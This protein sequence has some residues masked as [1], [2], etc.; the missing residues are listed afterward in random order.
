V[1]LG[2]IDITVKVSMSAAYTAAPRNGHLQALLHLFAYL[3][4]HDR[5]KLVFDD[6]YVKITD[7]IDVDWKEFYR[8]ARKDIPTNVPEARG[9]EVKMTV[10][11][12]A[13]YA[14]DKVTRRSRIGV[15]LYLN[16]SP[17]LWYSKKQNSVETSTFG[18]EFSALR[19]AMELTKSMRLK[20]RMMGIPL[21]GQAHFRV[22][23]ML[24]VHNMTNP[25]SMLK[26][27]SNEISYHYVREGMAS[28]VGR[29]GYEE[30]K[31]NHADM[32]TQVQTGIERQRIA[33][34][35]LY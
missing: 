1:E 3:N 10:F 16:K 32:L 14:G 15:L 22:N 19:T 4:K 9:R 29:V 21:D 20:L 8:N 25:G 17:I 24:V 33:S 35:V 7:E 2:R 11:V 26:K 12:D 6:S 34:C 5:S 18:S 30:S 31:S 28:G 13:D 27:N 23:N